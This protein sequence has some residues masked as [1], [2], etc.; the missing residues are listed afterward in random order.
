MRLRN[1]GDTR[2]AASLFQAVERQALVGVMTERAGVSVPS[3]DRI[4]R[5]GDT[6]LLV[7]EWVDGCSLD[8]LPAG[9]I[10]DDLLAR[11]WAEVG[12]LHRAGIAHRSLRAANVMVSP[13]GQPTIVD[14]S[15]SELAATAPTPGGLGAIE[16]LL[17]AGLTGI[18]IPSGPAVSAVL[19]YRLA[20]YWLPVP[21]GWL[22]WRLLQRMAYI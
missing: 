20:T 4:V 3:V 15:F 9:Q 12:N 11:L 16:A 1:V 18:G 6:A 17:A 10:D 8:R 13:A 7:M 14:F 2:P 22:S 21:P 5:A 19:L